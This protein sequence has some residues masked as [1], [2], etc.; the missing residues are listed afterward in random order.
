MSI[1]MVGN[2]TGIMAFTGATATT[3][4]STGH[5]P[6]PQKGQQN[7]VLTGGG[8]WAPV[9][10][11]LQPIAAA[12]QHVVSFTSIP[13]AATEIT[14]MFTDVSIPT[15]T[16]SDFMVRLGYGEPIT[17]VDSGYICTTMLLID[18]NGSEQFRAG[19]GI[20]TNQPT[21]S[22]NCVLRISPSSPSTNMYLMSLIGTCQY[23]TVDTIYPIM[24]SGS[25]NMSGRLTGLYVAAATGNNAFKF[26]GGSISVKYTM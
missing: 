22:L 9:N 24:S 7:H 19:L 4:G 26:G 14:V 11:Y 1:E 23:G 2:N 5:I 17:W 3:N 25:L 12:N 15:R 10:T 18:P 13:Q 16:A 6:M 20:W 8:N 21:R